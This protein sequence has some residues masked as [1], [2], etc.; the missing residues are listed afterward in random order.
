MSRDIGGADVHVLARAFGGGC[1]EVVGT[2]LERVAARIAD[3]A[4]CHGCRRSGAGKIC[5]AGRVAFLGIRLAERINL[6]RRHLFLLRRALVAT[7]GRGVD[8]VKAR[9]DCDGCVEVVPGPSMQGTG[10]HDTNALQIYEY[11]HK[12]NDKGHPYSSPRAYP[13]GQ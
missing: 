7:A 2:A 3:L 11:T 5:A 12:A 1:L 10:L 8:A 13:Q 6:A 4:L 9:V